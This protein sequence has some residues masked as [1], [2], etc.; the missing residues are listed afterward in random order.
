MPASLDTIV[1]TLQNIVTA[2][3]SATTNYTNIQGTQDFFN[4]TAPAVIKATSGRIVKISLTV[5]GSADGTVY[6]ANTVADT[7]RPIYTISHLTAF[8]TVG[9]PVQ[10]G[11]M[12]VPGSGMTVAGSFS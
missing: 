4:I 9:L 12:I 6:D 3:N 1:T 8:Q 10:Y 2:I 7:S 5:P 11:V